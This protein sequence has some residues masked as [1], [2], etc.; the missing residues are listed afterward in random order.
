MTSCQKAYWLFRSWDAGHRKV[1]QGKGVLFAKISMSE[2]Q[3]ILSRVLNSSNHGLLWTLP[4]PLTTSNNNNNHHHPDNTGMKSQVNNN[5]IS[6]IVFHIANIFSV[7]S[8]FPFLLI[9]AQEYQELFKKSIN[10]IE[11][12]NKSFTR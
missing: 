7:L 11:N 5:N 2:Q 8:R 12:N 1:R 9:S 6:F 10:S 3:T 4:Y